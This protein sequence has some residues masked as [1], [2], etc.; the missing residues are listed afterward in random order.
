[1]P[2]IPHVEYDLEKLNQFRSLAVR[3]SNNAVRFRI[4]ERFLC[5]VDRWLLKLASSVFDVTRI[6]EAIHTLK[7]STLDDPSATLLEA[8]F[9]LLREFQLWQQLIEDKDRSIE[10]Y[11]F[12]R[13]CDSSV[14]PFD[15]EIFVALASFYRGTPYS[16]TSQSK[17]DLVVTRLFSDVDDTGRRHLRFNPNQIAKRVE[18]VLGES[19]AAEDKSDRF[20]DNAGAVTAIHSF[21]AE[22][23]GLDDFESLIE[24]RLFDRYREFKLE[25]GVQFFEPVVIAAAVQCNVVFANAFNEMLEAANENLSEILTSEI[26]IPSALHDPAPEAQ[27]HLSDVLREFFNFE[28]ADRPIREGGETEHIWEL[29]SLAGEKAA[30]S[31]E[32]PDPLTESPGIEF[33]VTQSARE[34]LMPF[35]KTLTKTE[36][37]AGLL[38]GQLNRTKSLRALNLS[39]FLYS[40]DHSADVRTR[41]ILGLILWSEEFLQNELTRRK[42]LTPTAQHEVLSLIQKSEEFAT[43]L[44]SEIYAAEEASKSRLLVVL[45]SLLE[46]RLRLE[47]AIVRFTNRNFSQTRSDSHDEEKT[48]TVATEPAAD[49]VVVDRNSS[50]GRWLLWVLLIAALITAAFYFYP[51]SDTD[52]APTRTATQHIDISFLPNHEFIRDA[53]RRESTMFVTVQE[54]WTK[55]PAEKQKAFLKNLLEYPG[56][57]PYESVV[58]RDSGGRLLGNISGYGVYVP[59]EARPDPD[60]KSN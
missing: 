13:F 12:R 46:S 21:I 20:L 5:E 31:H 37:D 35:L 47:G 53:Y 9:Q 54:S 11:N 25:L 50:S 38:L 55:L 28:P 4:V 57:T 16:H 19:G 30:S 1:M 26:D 60:K 42:T 48:E 39:D 15:N 2:T 49:D 41:R 52:L 18:Q 32:Y 45:N 22:A 8:E 33:D 17:F 24:C 27:A 7:T 10:T 43:I 14:E 36:P 6:K 56:T 58:L 44:R 51:K 3:A 23:H 29:L 40:E 59:E 34:R